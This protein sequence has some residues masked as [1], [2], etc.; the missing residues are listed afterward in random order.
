MFECRACLLRGLRAIAGDACNAQTVSRGRNR[1][2]LTPRLATPPIRRAAS[3]AAATK[4]A[5]PN[6]LIST[7]QFNEGDAFDEAD[8]KKQKGLAIKD[9]RALR[10][11]LKYLSDPLKL[12]EHVRYTLRCNKP[13]KALDLCRLASKHQEVIVSWNHCVDWHMSQGRVDE[14][15]KIYNEMKKRAQF[16]DS[17]TY[18]LLLRGLAK[19]KHPGAV[20][21]Q[22]RVVKALSIYNSMSSPTSRVRPTIY[23]TNATLKV[24]SEALDMDSLWTVAATLPPKGR[25]AADHMTYAIILNA[26]RHGAVGDT[27]TDAHLDQVATRRQDAVNHGRRIWQEVIPKWRAGEVHVDEELICAMGRLL[28]ISQRTQDW[29][30]VF[31]LLR[32]TMNIERQIA[33][34]GSA[35]RHTEHIP[36][37]IPP[38]MATEEP[39]EDADG[40]R[41]APSTKAFSPVTPLPPDYSQ[42]GR[43]TQLAYVTPTNPTLSML[44]GTCKELRIPKVAIAYWNLITSPHGPYRVKADLHNYH[45]KFRLLDMNRSSARAIQVLKGMPPDIARTAATFRIVMSCC[46][47]DKNNHNVLQHARAVID[48]MERYYSNPTDLDVRTLIQYLNLAMLTDDGPKMLSALERL[49]TTVQSL[50]STILEDKK[51]KMNEVNEQQKNQELLTFFQTLVGVIDRLL[52]RKLIPADR[53]QD[54][55]SRRGQL[56]SLITRLKQKVH[57]RSD[58]GSFR[59]H[60]VTGGEINGRGQP[61]ERALRQLR[62]SEKGMRHREQGRQRAFGRRHWDT[63]RI[64]GRPVLESGDG[65]DFADSPMELTMR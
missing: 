50:R 10:T 44:I 15:I 38:P 32:Q 6:D 57:G 65:E 28:L 61:G 18:T 1:L 4:Q 30:D 26:L 8:A 29:D 58:K 36:R 62:W 60:G 42:P 19:P 20:V 21:E 52:N 48:E 47:R 12:A 41:D 46:V 25:S 17:Y 2:V 55:H 49:D 13:D 35:D 54:W 16:P 11:E 3:T 40:Y 56:T 51:P 53:A 63:E 39:A 5:R 33:P 24:C 45:A 37:G 59:V 31:N 64:R 14:A 7:E 43:P 9:E 34:I 22:A 23:H 27:P